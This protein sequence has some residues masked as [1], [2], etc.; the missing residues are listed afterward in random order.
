MVRR[1]DYGAVE[2]IAVVKRRG[3]MALKTRG[4]TRL[5]FPS[6]GFILP[7]TQNCLAQSK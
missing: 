4:A 7:A 1:D 2:R 6:N 5:I 3:Q